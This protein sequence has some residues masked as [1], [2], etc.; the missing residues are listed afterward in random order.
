MKP[1]ALKHALGVASVLSGIGMTA[2]AA[3]GPCT[4]IDHAVGCVAMWGGTDC[5]AQAPNARSYQLPNPDQ[6]ANRL[7]LDDRRCGWWDNTVACR[8][9]VAGNLP[10][11]PGAECGPPG[12]RSTTNCE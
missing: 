10:P 5:C 1:I 8:A 9:P 4:H 6:R 11:S 7:L 3:T 2:W 12:G